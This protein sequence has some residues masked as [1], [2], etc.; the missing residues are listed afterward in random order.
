[1]NNVTKTH[2]VYAILAT[3]R[4]EFGR[5]SGHWD[6]GAVVSMGVTR[7]VFTIGPDANTAKMLI[8]NYLRSCAPVAGENHLPYYAE[9]WRPFSE[10]GL[11]EMPSTQVALTPVTVTAARSLSKA[12]LVPAAARPCSCLAA[13]LLGWLLLLLPLPLLGQSGHLLLPFL[14]ALL[15]I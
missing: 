13:L 9:K 7:A 2:V 15:L 5:P 14:L 1:M 8:L 12:T 11:P 4:H 6:L 3:T 10:L